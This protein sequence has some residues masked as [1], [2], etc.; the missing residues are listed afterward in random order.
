MFIADA[1]GTPGIPEPPTGDSSMIIIDVSDKNDIHQEGS[2]NTP[3]S[4]NDVCL[5]G[6]Y[7]YIAESIIEGEISGFRVLNVTDK[8][9]PLLV[10]YANTGSDSIDVSGDYAYC[11]RG[12]SRLEIVGLN[13]FPDFSPS[14]NGYSFP[15]FDLNLDYTQ[16]EFKDFFELEL[17]LSD[18]EEEF[19]N[20]NY[21]M[22]SKS[23][24]YGI[25][26]TTGLFFKD[27]LIKSQYGSSI[28]FD[29][30]RG[31]D[32]EYLIRDY[33]LKQLSEE[34]LLKRIGDKEKTPTEYFDE[35]KSSIDS[36]GLVLII[37][38]NPSAT[39]AVLAYDYI[40]RPTGTDIVYMC[41]PNLPFP[42]TDDFVY[43]PGHPFWDGFIKFTSSTWF[44]NNHLSKWDQSDSRMAIIPLSLFSM[45]HGTFPN[46]TVLVYASGSETENWI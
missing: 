32:L 20:K 24:C 45:E 33:Q 30:A 40:D 16:E 44:Y 41:D 5:I 12:F 28:V 31:E 25:S 43:I 42:Y 22:G 17:P 4:C 23:Y 15:I 21:D 18:K 14:I 34:V 7:A 2:Y 35:I 13:Y 27:V 29:L 1:E 3:G 38:D 37:L 36:D 6:D 26:S 39:H 9:N 19:F 8:Q 46:D 10:G 11:T